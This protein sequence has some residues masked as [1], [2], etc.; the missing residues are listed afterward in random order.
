L[1]QFQISLNLVKLRIHFKSL[2]SNRPTNSAVCCCSRQAASS[3][4]QHS[5]FIKQA[6]SQAE[7]PIFFSP[8]SRTKLS[9][10]PLPLLPPSKLRCDAVVTPP[11]FPRASSAPPPPSPL[12]R[13]KL[14]FHATFPGDFEVFPIAVVFLVQVD[15]AG[16]APSPPGLRGPC[17]GVAL[18]FVKLGVRTP[19]GFV[20][21]SELP[22]PSEVPAST[23]LSPA[24]V[25][26]PH[27]RPTAIGEPPRYPRCFPPIFGVS[28]HRKRHSNWAPVCVPP[29]AIESRRYALL[30]NNGAS[31]LNSLVQCGQQGAASGRKASAQHQAVQQASLWA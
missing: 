29:A 25:R 28:S 26:L 16:Y 15:A 31:P 19:S 4:S 11:P 21:Y 27:H 7:R 1:L 8:V 12:H 5:S 9:A 24:F 13:E 18:R 10:A 6:S 22:T 14:L 30:L 3:P 17:A 23:S 20:N 2:Q